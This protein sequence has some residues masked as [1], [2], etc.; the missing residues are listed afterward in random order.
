MPNIKNFKLFFLYFFE[1]ST[2]QYFHDDVDSLKHFFR[3]NHMILFSPV[4]SRHKKSHFSQE[5]QH[6]T[7]TLHTSQR[8]FS[9]SFSIDISK[10]S[11]EKILKNNKYHP[12]HIEMDQALTDSAFKNRLNLCNSIF[13]IG[14]NFKFF[15]FVSLSDEATSLNSEVVNRHNFSFYSAFLSI[16][17]VMLMSVSEKAEDTLNILYH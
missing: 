14:Q 11:V 9:V 5:F 13:Q 1:C 8:K 4:S 7:E 12:Y 15:E 10:R 2:M 6:T 17:P 16:S 3:S